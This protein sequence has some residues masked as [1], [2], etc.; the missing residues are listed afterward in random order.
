MA[1]RR[2]PHSSTPTWRREYRGEIDYIRQD[3]PSAALLVMNRIHA[4]IREVCLEP[5]IGRP[6]LIPGTREYP[7]R[8]TRLL[9]IYLE[10]AEEIVL[11]NC[12]HT[13]RQR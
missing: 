11:L 4:A 6:G 9:L 3:S 12:W 1:K 5:G 7:I 2:K 8:K 13:S 10:D